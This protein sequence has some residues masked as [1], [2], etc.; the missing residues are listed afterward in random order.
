[1][2]VAA[3]DRLP[4][5]S[6]QYSGYL[7][8]PAAGTSHLR[9][10]RKPFSERPWALGIID[11]A[12][13]AANWASWWVGDTLGVVAM[14]PLVMIVAG[15]PRAL[16]QSR[17]LT[18]AVPILLVLSTGL[19]AIYFLQNAA[20]NTA[21]QIQRDNFDYQGREITLRIEQRLAAYEQVL[22]GVQRSVCRVG[23]C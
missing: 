5:R 14:F 18:I 21:R 19:A 2:G 3:G 22:R 23:E 6:Q 20:I 4:G 16:W 10:Q 9:D 1:M 11:T 8:F 17:V 15:G 7:A 13:I 12:G